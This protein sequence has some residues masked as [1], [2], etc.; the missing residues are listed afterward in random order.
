MICYPTKTLAI[1]T[2][3]IAA[4]WVGASRIMGTD[5]E[6]AITG[7]SMDQ[8][9]PL[10]HQIPR[11]YTVEERSTGYRC[12]VRSE[13]SASEDINDVPSKLE[14]FLKPLLPLAEIIRDHNCIIRVAVFS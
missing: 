12:V 5:I 9:E 1:A 4:K 6:L 13:S 11:G 3:V 7:L 8:C 2:V 14:K 10:L